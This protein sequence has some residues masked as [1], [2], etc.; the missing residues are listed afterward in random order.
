MNPLRAAVVTAV[1]IAPAFAHAAP[2]LPGAPDSLPLLYACA[3]DECRDLSGGIQRIVE[4]GTGKVFFGFAGLEASFAAGTLVLDG[5]YNTDPFIVFGV[6]STIIADDPVTFS[7]LL[8]TP[9]VPGLYN[10]ATSAGGVAVTT[11][12]NGAGAVSSGAI[13]P[14]FIAGYGTLGA[15]PT[16]LGV[17]L[18]AAPCVAGPGA[19]ATETCD[20]GTLSNLLAATF[21]DN[22]EALLTYTQ[23]GS[24]SVA[25]WSGAVVLEAQRVP[26]PALLALLSGGIVAVVWRRRRR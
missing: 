2:L 19:A 4:S 6:S 8:G 14:S 7:I 18:G 24:G 13:Q 5:F 17:G 23:T 1:F 16:D 12:A 21:F 25:S 20:Q 11:G 9:V 22:L 26:E 10:V 15:V 3:N